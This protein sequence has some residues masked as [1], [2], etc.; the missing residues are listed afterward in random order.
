MFTGI[1]QI[2]NIVNGSVYI[3]SSNDMSKRWIDHRK[4]LRKNTHTNQHLQN[5]WNKYGEQSFSFVILEHRP[6]DSK[7][8]LLYREQEY[9]DLYLLK[10]KD[11]CYNI[12]TV[13][14]SGPGP[15][16]GNK[17]STLTK[18]KQS[19]GLVGNTNASGVIRS[20]E[21]KEKL[22][23]ANKGE[24]NSGAKLTWEKVRLIR[25]LW[26]ATDATKKDLGILFNVDPYT[27]TRIIRCDTWKEQ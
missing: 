5:A 26:E 4:L 14:G 8:A 20:S 24:K 25:A 18:Q 6:N 11:R 27:I 16:V 19:A 7:K 3:G 1:Y 23:N 22:S 17:H 2:Q 12:A 10:Y 15:K 21:F 13:A 9:L